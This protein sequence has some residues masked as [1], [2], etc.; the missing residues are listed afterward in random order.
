M[1]HK[2]DHIV[3]LFA[4]AF[5]EIRKAGLA[6][7]LPKGGVGS[8]LLAHHLQHE[9]V[10]GD[11][12]ADAKDA[13]GQK[14]EYKVSI[15]DQFNFHFGARN[16]YADP[17]E[18]VRTHFAKITGAYSALRVAEKFTRIVYCPSASLVDDLCKHFQNTAGGQLNKN[19]RLDSFAAL[20]NAKVIL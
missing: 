17:T 1:A 7:V 2:Y 6:D 20:P 11:K 10:P 4:Q 15:T 13:S 5:N 8:I 16:A 19:F 18:P 9:L 14:F 12:G 3:A